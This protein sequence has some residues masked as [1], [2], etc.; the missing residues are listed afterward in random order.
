[1][2]SMETYRVLI[3][4][5]NEAIHRDFRSLLESKVESGDLLDLA[6]EVF[7]EALG[8]EPT[9]DLPRYTFDS[10]YQ[11]PD[12]L[13]TVKKAT[14]TGQSY[15]LA[16]VDVRMPPGW[17][18]VE[19]IQRLW[20][21]DPNIQ[22]IICSAYAD[23]SW[24]QIVQELGVTDK[25]LLLRKPFDP[26]SVKQ[27]ALAVACRWNRE[28]LHRERIA[29]LEALVG[30]HGQELDRLRPELDRLTTEVQAMRSQ[31]DVNDKTRSERLSRMR[32]E[33]LALIAALELVL[34]S[35]L[36]EAQ[37]TA[38]ESALKSGRALLEEL[39]RDPMA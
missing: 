17:D 6:L 14:S 15:T 5:D 29:E 20:E 13:E 33:L 24:D 4:D 37:R 8:T 34:A 22:M 25:L 18:G 32:T 11:G 2:Q 39:A 38:G 23:Y 1:M 31:R 3:V 27:M 9:P 16:F 7:G 21:V 36:P 10:A 12:A 28:R 30:K 26:N 19:T 35:P